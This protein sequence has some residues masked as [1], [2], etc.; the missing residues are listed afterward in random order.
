M[1]TKTVEPN[2]SSWRTLLSAL[3]PR[4]FGSFSLLLVGAV[5]VTKSCTGFP[6]SSR[7]EDRC[8]RPVLHVEEVTVVKKTIVILLLAGCNNGAFVVSDCESDPHEA[9]E[10]YASERHLPSHSRLE[11]GCASDAA[12]VVG[13][14]AQQ[15]RQSDGG[16]GGEAD[17][18][19]LA[20]P[21]TCGSVRGQYVPC[22]P[23]GERCEEGSCSCATSPPEPGKTVCRRLTPDWVTVCYAP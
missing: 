13:G 8:Q 2:T 16:T 1:Q 15:Q 7:T 10:G 3:S 11:E 22:C 12:V 6:M 17:A 21:L 23:D 20:W 4:T 5:C 18:I 14:D 9:S 19:G